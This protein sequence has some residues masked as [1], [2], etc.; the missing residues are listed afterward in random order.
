MLANTSQKDILVL[1]GDWNAREGRD[2]CQ[3]W[4][5]VFGSCGT[6]ETNDRERRLLEFA[7]NHR[8]NL[9]NTLHPHK[10]SMTATW[11]G[12]RGQVH[13]QID[14]ILTPQRFKSSINK[15][16]ARSFPGA[17]T[18]SDHDLVLTTIKLKL[19]TKRFTKV[20]ASDLTRRNLKTRKQRKCGWTVCS[21][22]CPLQQFRHPCRQSKRSAYVQ[23]LKRSLENRGKRFNL[24]S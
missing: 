2:A 23:Q 6:G 17:D 11:L 13:D 1:Q 21:F 22:L 5:G 19:K 24:G 7:R 16:N 3:H 9:A 14:L 10:L 18:G 15:E 4:A 20:L 12:P 8:L